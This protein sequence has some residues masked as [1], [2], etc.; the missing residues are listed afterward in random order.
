MQARVGDVTLNYEIEGPREAPVVTLSHSLAS[1]LPVWDFQA[2]ALRGANR[3][4]RVDARGH[5]GSSAPPGPYTIEMISR[6]II[7]LLDYLEI[8]QTHFVGISMGGMIGQVLGARYPERIGKLVLCDTSGHTPPEAVPIWQERIARVERA[9]LSAVAD[10]TLERWLSEEF[11]RSRPEIARRIR[12]MIVNTPV[13]G[14]VGCCHAISGWDNLA[15]LS[16]IRA[17]TL[18][19]VGEKDESAPVSAAEVL[20]REI[21]GSELCV[22]PGARHLPNIEAA[23]LFNQKLTRFLDH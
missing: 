23:A 11:R 10:E 15:E 22:I 4:L 8:R 3:V 18:I 16:G 5:G 20:R 7:G 21:G 9:G 17:R 19:M 6:D 2:I 1:A 13:A 14:Y 12:D